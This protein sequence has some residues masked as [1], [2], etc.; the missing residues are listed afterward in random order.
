MPVRTMTTSSSASSTRGS[1]AS[2]H[3]YVTPPDG[4]LCEAP[5]ASITCWGAG[6]GVTARLFS[7]E[8]AHPAQLRKLTLVRVEHIVAG[9]PE[10]R[11][12]NRALPLAEHHRVGRLRL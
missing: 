4:T 7:P 9:V 2:S 1:S 3:E 6:S 10:R 8:Q 5:A 12:D 11:L